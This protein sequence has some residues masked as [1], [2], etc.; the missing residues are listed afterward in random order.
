M[1]ARLV[2]GLTLVL[3]SIV[4]GAR[5]VSGAHRTYPAV[6]VAHD[7]EAG[8]VLSATDLRLIRVRLADRALY[9]SRPDSAIG[10]R[11]SR[12]LSKGELVPR[13]ALEP[14][15]SGTR[16][17][18]AFVDNAAPELAAG[19]RVSVWLVGAHCPPVLVVSDVVVQSVRE[20]PG[21][22]GSG[23]GQAIDI[24]VVPEAVDRVLAAVSRPDSELR[25]GLLSGAANSRDDTAPAPIDCAAGS[26]GS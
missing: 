4:I 14:G 2:V 22:V 18:I 16:I 25:A 20:A 13:S 7:A 11:L 1:D 19:E 6:V 3:G 24:D 23:G 12:P 5:V 17:T 10:G 9:L 26:A 21:G 15:R 8:T